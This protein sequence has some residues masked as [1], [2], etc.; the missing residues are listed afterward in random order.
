MN[1]RNN[2]PVLFDSYDE[3]IKID[4]TRTIYDG[5]IDMGG[6]PDSFIGVTVYDLG[7]DGKSKIKMAEVKNN[8][9][10]PSGYFNIDY[11]HG[12]LKVDPAHYEKHKLKVEFYSRGIELTPASRI[13]SVIDCE[14][15][16]GVIH[17][18]KTLQDYLDE[19]HNALNFTK[20]DSFQEIKP[21]ETL[22]NMLGKI[23]YWYDHIKN[24]ILTYS[25]G[26]LF[27]HVKLSDSINSTSSSSSHIAAT[28]NAIK[29]V[30][31]ALDETDNN[32]SQSI[33]SEARTR[34]NADIALG[35]RI[36]SEI[37][38]RTNADSN[39]NQQIKDHSSV[40]GNSSLSG[41]VQL[42]DAVNSASGS[43]SGIAA[44]PKAVKQAYDKASEKITAERLADGAVTNTKISENAVTESKLSSDLQNKI[45]NID[46]SL[47]LDDLKKDVYGTGTLDRLL[48][49]NKNS[50]I[51]AI[52]EN[53]GRISSLGD[54]VN[55]NKSY[56][57]E[58]LAEINRS[59]TELYN[60]TGVTLYD[61]GLFGMTQ[62]SP[63]FDGG[64][65]TDTD[66]MSFDCGGFTEM[67]GSIDCGTY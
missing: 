58:T 66:L 25:T 7:T 6:L 11:L 8:P 5:I 14:I 29:T 20:A 9:S 64:S 10:P 62:N 40:K 27:G 41:H 4:E 50:V 61:G 2:N 16:G 1:F 37:T 38:A 31:D 24:H 3:E 46:H 22:K 56:I 13:Y 52:N 65:F 55:I 33:N 67:V 51:D 48:T 36:D 45:N 26:S 21:K 34:A 53:S 12:W 39:L 23:A 63:D 17:I 43:S 32:L 59:I 47:D 54:T 49:S 28:P 57:S 44:T 60:L 19:I 18:E 30:K 15:N 35:E 42:S